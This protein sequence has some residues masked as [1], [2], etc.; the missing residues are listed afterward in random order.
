MV[1]EFSR[2]ARDVEVWAAIKEMGQ[3]GIAGL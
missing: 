3:K 2:R 1:P